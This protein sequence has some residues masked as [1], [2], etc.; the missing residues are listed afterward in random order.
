MTD[1]AAARWHADR[2]RGLADTTLSSVQA[3]LPAVQ[4]LSLAAAAFA[5]DPSDPVALA[6]A[7]RRTDS[8]LAGAVSALG[9]IHDHLAMMATKGAGDVGASPTPGSSGA[10]A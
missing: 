1:P 7:F 3:T 8:A 10:E 4:A 2:V 9:S 6:D 5:A